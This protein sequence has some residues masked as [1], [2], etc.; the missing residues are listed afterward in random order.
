MMMLPWV[1]DTEHVHGLFA[2]LGYLCWQ[3]I[4]LWRCSVSAGEQ[5]A[6]HSVHGILASC[7]WC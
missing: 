6:A 4:S 5:Q 2:L 3:Q 1:L 7:T